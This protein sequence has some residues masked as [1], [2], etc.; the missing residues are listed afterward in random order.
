MTLFFSPVPNLLVLAICSLLAIDHCVPTRSVNHKLSPV[1]ARFV[2]SS[3]CFDCMHVWAHW[4]VNPLIQQCL[5]HE[6]PFNPTLSTAH[7]VRVHPSSVHSLQNLACLPWV[8]EPAAVCN[9]LCSVSMCFSNSIKFAFVIPRCLLCTFSVAMDDIVNLGDSSQFPSTQLPLDPEGGFPAAVLHDLMPDPC[10]PMSGRGAVSGRGRNNSGRSSPCSSQSQ[11]ALP[12]KVRGP[13]WT[14]AEMLVL[15]GEK[16]LEW[17]ARHNCNQPSLAKFVYGTTTWKAVLAGCMGVVVFRVRDIDQI[18]NKWDGLIKDYKKLK[19][20]IEASG[21]ANWWGMSRVQKKDLFRTRKMSLEFSE[22][23]YTEM[24]GF[25]GK[26]SIFGRSTEVVD[27]DRTPPPVARQSQR[28]TP[29]PRAPSSVGTKIPPAAVA[30]PSDSPTT[31]TPGHDTPG[32]TGQKRKY[33]GTDNL[34]DFV[35]DFN[36]DY[37]ARMEALD[38]DRQTWRTDVLAFDTAREAR[39]RQKE[40]ESSHMDQKFYEL[41]VERTRHLGNM[42]SALLML[43]SSM[44]TLTR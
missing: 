15:I 32:S 17:D 40:T 28:T 43:A 23:M 36:H 27:S 1:V 24:E 2:E 8:P 7:C 16:R 37:L 22:A 29:P 26:R 12:H 19:D 34:V 35:K 38:S 11:A 30:T 10:V 5:W 31:A 14:E 33:V 13:N 9:H 3:V 44:D 18:T 21:S 42:S 6:H 20:Y 41:E 25:V 39:I 4:E